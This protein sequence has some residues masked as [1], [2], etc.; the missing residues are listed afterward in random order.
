MDICMTSK[1]Y[2]VAIIGGGPAGSTAAT[3]L[4]KAGRRVIVFE[5]EKFPRFHIGESLLPF[6]MQAFD[7]L[8]LREKLDRTF[9]PKYGGEIMSACGSR[10]VKFYFKDGF[11]SQRDRSYQVT[12]SEFDKLLL[13]HSQEN[14][15]EVR[16]ETEVTKLDFLDGRVKIDIQQVDGARSTID[17]RYLLDCSG[18]QTLLGG[19][20]DL[21]NTYDHL[22]KFSVFAHYDNVDRL[23]GKDATLIRMVRGLDRW[24]WMIPLTERRT[25]IGVVMDTSTFRATKLAPEPALE[26]FIAEQPL[27]VERMKNAV[28]VS[29]V[30]SAGDYSYRNKCLAGD[31]WLLVGDAAGFIDPVFSSGVFLAIMSAEKAAD[32][33]EEVL[34][35]ESKRRRLFN[36]YSRTV[37]R[38]MDIYLTFVNAWYQ[39]SKEFLEVFLNPTETMQ[40][41]AAVN[42]VLAGN[43]GKSFAVKWRMWVFYFF[44]YAQRFFSFSPRLSLV[45]RQ[46]EA[47]Q[48]VTAAS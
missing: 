35:D 18:R 42:A 43:A 40:I 7:R 23:P 21:K 22:Q 33:L 44:V 26:K 20:F 2:D 1:L 11:R 17:A 13:D 25:S 16:E 37:N 34:S 45:P 4:A 41:A 31:R 14:G 47:P 6:S 5:R 36:K 46:D 48:P 27:M 19:L 3:L 10:G 12:R 38:V 39:R 24:F 9:L 28:R 32:T 30:Y 29:P 8:G 15:A